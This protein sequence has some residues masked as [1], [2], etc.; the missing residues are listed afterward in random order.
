MQEP[1]TFNGR[2]LIGPLIAE[3]LPL[4]AAEMNK[5]QA[6]ILPRS[7]FEQ[8]ET[9]RADRARDEQVSGSC[10]FRL[11]YDHPLIVYP[12]CT[13]GGGPLSPSGISLREATPLAI[14]AGCS[15]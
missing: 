8:M 2:R 3:L 1:K 11:V 7:L 13:T 4:L 5:K 10:H 15:H 12:A 9:R 6:E 14:G